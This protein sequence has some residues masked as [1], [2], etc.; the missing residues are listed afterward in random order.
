M[1]VASCSYPLAPASTQPT[2]YKIP[3][4]FDLEPLSPHFIADSSAKLLRFL[5]NCRDVT[6]TTMADTATEATGKSSGAQH[7]KRSNLLIHPECT[8]C[9]AKDVPL[10]R[11][12]DYKEGS[13]C[14]R[15]CQKDDW[16]EHKK[17][18]M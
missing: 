2:I 15:T 16:K 7:Q 8:N 12:A 3:H 18:C 10:Q 11:C 4:P 5:A 14:S 6:T 9:H 1:R 17:Q 13:Y